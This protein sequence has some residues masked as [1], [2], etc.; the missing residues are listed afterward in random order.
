MKHYK[1]GIDIDNVIC[2]TSTAVVN[3]IN[4]RLPV[5]LELESLSSY[6][7]ENFLPD[8]YKWIVETAFNDSAMWRQVKLIDGAAEY[9]EKLYNDG[10]ELYFATA[11]TPNNFKKKIG[12]L[13]RSFPFL[14]EGYV[15]NHFFNIKNKGMLRVD[16]LIDDFLDNLL[17]DREYISFCMDYPW[18]QCEIED[19][20]FIRVKNWK[21]FYDKINEVTFNG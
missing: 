7:I 18:N 19:K 6:W 11:T 5:N 21:E 16:I 15:I 8:Q 14:P 3:Y 12:F 4:E 10:H 20:K 9:I 17:C 1:I 13:E 2:D